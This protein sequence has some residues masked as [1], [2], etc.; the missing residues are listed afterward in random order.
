MVDG[1][2][3]GKVESYTFS[4]VSKNYSIQVIFEGSTFVIDAQAGAG[5]TIAPFASCSDG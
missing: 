3:V 2:S 4:N 1:K 5:G